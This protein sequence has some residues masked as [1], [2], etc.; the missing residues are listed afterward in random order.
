MDSQKGQL[1]KIKSVRISSELLEMLEREI[2]ARETSFS[3]YVR[4]AMTHE[5]KYGNKPAQPTSNMADLLNLSADIRFGGDTGNS[6]KT[7]VSYKQPPN[8]PVT[9]STGVLPL[10]VMTTARPCITRL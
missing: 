5:M 7:D 9:H 10:G 8:L 6:S 4:H 1:K 3:E 2:V